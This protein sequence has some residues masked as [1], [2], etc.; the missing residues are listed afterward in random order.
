VEQLG[1]PGIATPNVR[2]FDFVR[3]E[4]VEIT[5][6]FGGNPGLRSDDR[7][8]ISLGLTARPLARTDLTL[9]ADY[10]GTRIDNPIAAFPIA[11]PA[12]EAAFPERFTRDV[13]GRLVRIDARP[14]NFG[15]SDQQQLRFALNFTR[16]LGHVPPELRGA[17]MFYGQTEA[18]IQK[19][20]PGSVFVKT[21]PSA[22]MT[23]GVENLRS[24]LFL[25]AHYTLRLKDEIRVTDGAPVLDLLD[26]SA[27]GPRGGRP[28]HELEFQAGAF[29]GGLGAQLRAAWRSGTTVSGLPEGPGGT[30]GDLRFSDNGT[31]DINLFANLAE[32]FGGPKAPEWLKGTRIS[33]AISNLLD[34]RPR[35]RDITGAT[36]A[37]FHGAYLDPIG[38]SLS[39][40]LRKVF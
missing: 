29:K 12:L 21:P 35:V 20:Y 32:R 2:T 31:V 30:A 11:T 3:R 22:A 4:T 33:L 36:P 6:T 9:G 17:R 26:G 27:I 14:L 16:P 25:S 5:R 1:G 40:S 15:R 34:A 28:R 23:R 18:D 24:R 10:L 38:R 13:G 37:H 7:R 8:L 19:R 39:F